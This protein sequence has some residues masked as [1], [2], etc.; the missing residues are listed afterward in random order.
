[1]SMLSTVIRN[2][3]H[4]PVT[5]SYPYIPADIPKGNR[6]RVDWDMASCTLCGLCEKRCPTLAVAVDKRIGVV[7]LQVYR[8]ISCGVCADVCPKGVISI[9]QEYSSPSYKK[10]IRKYQKEATAEKAA[11]SSSD[12]EVRSG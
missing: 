10:E 4:R 6:G 2:L 3:V 11:E 5:T 12:S 1:M 7:S 9:R 8:C